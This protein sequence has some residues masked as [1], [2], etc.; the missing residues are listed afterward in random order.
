MDYILTNNTTIE[1]DKIGLFEYLLFGFNLDEKT[2]Y[3]NINRLSPNSKL[4]Y[5]IDSKT[6][7]KTVRPYINFENELKEMSYKES[8]GKFLKTFDETMQSRITKTSHYKPVIQLSGG[9]DSRATLYGLHKNKIKPSV[10]TYNDNIIQSTEKDVAIE[11][12]KHYGLDTNIINIDKKYENKWI[13]LLI[14]I[15]C[16]LNPIGISSHFKCGDEISTTYGPNIVVFSGLYG[17]EFTRYLDIQMDY[18]G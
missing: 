18:M 7:N 1:S 17:G 16:G 5:D 10:V 13:D 6:I 4:Y 9:L 11:I 14:D 15:K 8:I 2:L 12:A 3:K